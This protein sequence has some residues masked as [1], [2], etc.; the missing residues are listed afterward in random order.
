MLGDRLRETQLFGCFTNV[1][2]RNSLLITPTIFAEWPFCSTGPLYKPLQEHLS[3]SITF[4][5]HLDPT[6]V[7]IL[8]HCLCYSF[9]YLQSDGRPSISWT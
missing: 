5:Q 7:L 4:P 3:P 9:E 8:I 2:R 6:T 1:S